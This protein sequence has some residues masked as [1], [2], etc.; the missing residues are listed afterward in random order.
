MKAYTHLLPLRTSLLVTLALSLGCSELRA[1]QHAREG[2]R[3]FREGQY[4]AAVDAYAE[5]EALHPLPVV[6]FNKGLACRQLML[7]GAKTPNNDRAVDCALAAFSRLKQLNPADARADRLYQQTLFDADRF[8]ALASIYERALREDPK[9]PIALNAMIQVQARWG[10][11][12]DALRYTIVRAEQRR[13]DAEAQYAVGV[14]IYNRLFEKGGGPDKSNFDPRSEGADAKQTP[15]FG[16]GD[17]TGPERVRLAEQGI[18][19]LNRALAIRPN[20]SDALT[21]L[22]LLERQKSFALFDRPAEWQAAVESAQRYA[23]RAAAAHVK[24]A[25]KP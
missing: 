24:H 12:S 21:Y 16:T 5:S 17:I 19:Y 14:F 3:H 22:G 10:R 18:A 6:A 8:E 9:D 7:P 11:W 1:R 25:P 2:N 15:T 13:D 4:A 20:Y 23:V